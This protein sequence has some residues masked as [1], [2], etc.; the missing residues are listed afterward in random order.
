MSDPRDDPDAAQK[1]GWRN[2]NDKGYEILEQPYGFPAPR[3]IIC[4]GA[5]ATGIC[6][7]KFADGQ[8]NLSIEVYDKNDDVAGTW[9]ENR[10]PGCGCDIPSHIY[11]FMWSLNPSWSSYYAGAS[12]ILRYF[13]T[14]TREHGLEKYITL[15]HKATS[16]SWD[17]KI[18]KWTVVVERPDGSTF[19]D[20]CDFLVNGSGVL[21]NWKWPDIKGLHTFTGHLA[22]SADWDPATELEGKRVA[23]FGAGSSG[24]QIVSN[25]QPSVRHLYHWIRSPLWISGGLVSGFAGPNGDNF[26][27]TEET[28]RRFRSDPEM[29]LRYIKG[30]EDESNQG[31]QFALRNTK[32]QTAAVQFATQLMQQKLEKRPDI[33]EKIIP[34]TYGVGCR[35]PT[36]G[37]GYLESLVEPNV[38]IYTEDVREITP[39]GFIDCRGEPHEVDIIICKLHPELP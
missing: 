27:Y 30:L 21:N 20:T 35:R 13:Q 31:Y 9:T 36:P 37:H 14:V 24:I 19:L 2:R 28:K 15:R 34:K 5:G 32:G 10:Y 38:T 23:V 6:L 17:A 33:F 29:H 7:A 8:P 26:E 16:A 39:T 18:A 1:Y 11:Q 4:I 25:I 22:H 12:E 3:R